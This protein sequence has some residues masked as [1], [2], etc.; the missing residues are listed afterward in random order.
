M[1][2]ENHSGLGNIVNCI[3]IYFHEMLLTLGLSIS[4]Y[5]VRDC[6]Y[7]LLFILVLVL[8]TEELVW[9]LCLTL[10]HSQRMSHKNFKN[11]RNCSLYKNILKEL[12]FKMSRFDSVY[13]LSPLYLLY[14]E[15]DYLAIELP[16]LAPFGKHSSVVLALLGRLKS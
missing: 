8:F 14:F 15:D 11:M 6:Q 9:N 1:F 2:D 13:F 5:K 7:N 16:R 3:M 10:K 4:W 12:K